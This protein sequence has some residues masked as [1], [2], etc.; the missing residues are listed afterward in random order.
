MDNTDILIIGA[1]PAGI[2]ASLYAVRAGFD[3]VVLE[4]GKS[5]L[6][7]AEIIENYY[8]FAKGI[9]GKELLENGKAGAKALG[10]E[11]I[12]GEVTSIAFD[13][14]EGFTVKTTDGDFR[15]KSVIIATGSKRTKPKIENLEALE[16]MGVSYCA[17]CDGFLYRDKDIAVIGNSDYALSEATELLPFAN[18]VTLLT[19]GEEVKANFPDEIEIITK[20]ITSLKGKD[21]LEKVVFED[22]STIEVSGIFIAIGTA[23]SSELARKIGAFTDGTNITIDENM[24]TN[25]PGL[26]A[27]GDCTGGLLQVSTAVSEGA[28]AGTEATKFLRKMFSGLA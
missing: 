14:D 3:T 16:G 25:V 11:I 26:F 15:A 20:K 18:S 22:E 24:A 13:F 27:A 5:S 10:A 1:G 19:N 7:K 2:S 17:T 6:E 4:N 23:G 9:T 8:G 12:F 21:A 28:K